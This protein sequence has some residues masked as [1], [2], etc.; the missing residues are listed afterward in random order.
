[1]K[2]NNNT[3]HYTMSHANTHSSHHP[4]SAARG[5]AGVYPSRQNA[6]GQCFE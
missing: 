3:P 2:S 1:M 4:G 5:A 6:D